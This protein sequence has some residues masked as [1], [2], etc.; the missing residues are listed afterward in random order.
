[1]DCR[2]LTERIAVERLFSG[3]IC[4]LRQRIKKTLLQ[5]NPTMPKLDDISYKDS[6]GLRTV[7]ALSAFARNATRT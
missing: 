1:M 5:N 2:S 3:K 6:A 7:V 4:V